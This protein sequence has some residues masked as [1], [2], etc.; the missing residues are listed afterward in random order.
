MSLK[1]IQTD[2]SN[3]TPQYL[4]MKN[5]GEFENKLF[6][7]STNKPLPKTYKVNNI[8][9]KVIDGDLHDYLPQHKEQCI[10]GLRFKY[11]AKDKKDKRLIE[12][13]KAILSGFVKIA[14]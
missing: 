11:K 12:L 10:I 3:V 4:T 13:N 9:F 6:Y 2:L 8:D 5:K 14:S 7:H 1:D